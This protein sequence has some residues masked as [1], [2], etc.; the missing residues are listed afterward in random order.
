MHEASRSGRELVSVSI[1]SSI[2][3]ALKRLWVH[4]GLA[5]CLLL[6]LTIAV[7]LSVAVPMYADGVNYQ[8]LN[9]SLSQNGRNNG[10]PSFTFLFSY[11][12]TWHKPVSIDQ[13]RLVD[14]YLDDQVPG[15][16]ELPLREGT[17]GFIRLVSTGSLQLYPSGPINRSQRL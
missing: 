9:T 2:S 12:G 6:G 5:G 11:V 16:I 10:Q 14:A 17:E 13:Y 3:F 7:A 15:R 4:R 1:L 8:L